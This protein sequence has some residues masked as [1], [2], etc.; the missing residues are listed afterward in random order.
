MTLNAEN[1]NKQNINVLSIL[2][3]LTIFISLVNNFI[4]TNLNIVQIYLLNPFVKEITECK[5]SAEK[6]IRVFFSSKCM[7]SLFNSNLKQIEADSFR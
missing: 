2:F 7:E 1:K 3:G 5:V 6:H 4:P